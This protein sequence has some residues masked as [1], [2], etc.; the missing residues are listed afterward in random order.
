MSLVLYEL[1]LRPNVDPRDNEK[2]IRRGADLGLT[3]VRRIEERAALLS[4]LASST[5]NSIR[6]QSFLEGL[7]ADELA[8]IADF[9]GAGLLDPQLQP[10]S[11]RN[12]TARRI[13][14][15]QQLNAAGSGRQGD[16]TSHKMI[17]LLE[18]L[19]LTRPE[20][21]RARWAM[22]AGCA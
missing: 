1:R 14:R 6:V 8:Y 21:A 13:E 17:L 5:E 15:F 20:P 2:S 18:Y 16:Q 19:S 11:S 9:L 3:N 22:R 4:A 10:G 12:M 7:S